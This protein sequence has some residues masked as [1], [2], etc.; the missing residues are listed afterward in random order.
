MNNHPMFLDLLTI[1]VNH[2]N[3]HGKCVDEIVCKEIAV[4]C[5]TK[6]PR[7]YGQVLWDFIYEHGEDENCDYLG[8]DQYG[9][10]QYHTWNP[11]TNWH[12]RIRKELAAMGHYKQ[13]A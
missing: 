3:E 12:N 1:L 13:A 5:H 7:G 9:E 11:D 8:R 4:Y 10:K 2:I 6:A